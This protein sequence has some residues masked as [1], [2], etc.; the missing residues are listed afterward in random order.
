[1]APATIQRVP[2]RVYKAAPGASFGD[3]AAVKYGKFLERKAGLGKRLVPPEK[4]VDLAEPEDS[5]IHEE[6]TWDDSVA[7]HE[8]R[9]AQARKLVSHI[10]Y[11][12]G[13]DDEGKEQV[14]RAF[15]NVTVRNGD[16]QRGYVSDKVI[17]AEPK[18]AEQVIKSALRELQGWRDRYESYSELATAIAKVDEVLEE[19]A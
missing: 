4:I 18:L 6:F 2:P 7:A 12:V 9:L 1:M 14:S 8:Q 13:H 10:V 3:D 19:V 15:L 5:P 17:W 11:V 16:E